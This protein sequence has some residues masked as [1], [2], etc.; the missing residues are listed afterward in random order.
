MTSTEAAAALE[1]ARLSSTWTATARAWPK[2]NAAGV[3]EWE[4]ITQL[5]A[6]TGGVYDPAADA[7]LQDELAADR[8]AAEAEQ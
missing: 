4:R 2:T 3:A 1:D 7:V 6:T 8:G 5:L